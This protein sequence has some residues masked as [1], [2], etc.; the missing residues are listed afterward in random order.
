MTTT[1]APRPQQVTRACVLAGLGAALILVSVFATLSRWGSLDIR[2]QVEAVLRREPLRGSGLGTDQA[3]RWLRVVLMGVAAVAVSTIV[4]AVFTSRRHRGARAGLI[5]LAGFSG[6]VFLAGGLT[7]LLPALMSLACVAY[8][9]STDS[10]AWFAGQDPVGTVAAAAPEARPAR[11]DRPDPFATPYAA[12]PPPAYRSTVPLAPPRGR[13]RSIV[14]A[15]TVT[16]VMAGLVALV[17]VVN[18][19]SYA[20]SPDDYAQMLADQPMMRSSSVL[21][22][23]GITAAQ[24]AHWM[25]IATTSFAILSALAIVAA[26]LM[27]RRL[28]AA[29][30]LFTVVTAVAIAC[31]VALFPFGW[32]WAIGEIFVLVQVYRVDANEWFKAGRGPTP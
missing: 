22:D 16:A 10:R 12:A 27:L 4:L 1:P 25:F 19:I 20:S 31:S 21:D 32:V 24:L 23:L 29:R 3:L 28:P 15:V 5:V 2:E 14:T 7:G 8:L 13:P 6:V 18:V 30:V 9:F 26:L 11:T 17:C